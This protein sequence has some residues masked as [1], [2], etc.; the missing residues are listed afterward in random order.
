MPMQPMQKKCREPT[1]EIVENECDFAKKDSEWASD[2]R[3]WVSA[4]PRT[5]F[6]ESRPQNLPNFK[7]GRGA[8][9]LFV[10]QIDVVKGKRDF[11]V[12]PREIR[13]KLRPY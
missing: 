12:V 7:C 10:W 1:K 5:Y 6:N 9:I 4:L 13:T 3:V 8:Q 2:N 11:R